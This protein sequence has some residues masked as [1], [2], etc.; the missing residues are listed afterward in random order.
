MR[1]DSCASCVRN[2]H[3]ALAATAAAMLL[4]GVL[5]A[6]AQVGWQPPPVLVSGISGSLGAIFEPQIATDPAGNAVAVWMESDPAGGLAVY[7]ARY[8]AATHTWLAPERRS[9]LGVT[10]AAQ[11]R[12]AVD[13]AGQAV[14]MWEQFM[15]GSNSASVMSTRYSPSAGTWTTPEVRSNGDAQGV[16]VAMNAAGDA[17]AVWSVYAG[18][19]G[20]VPS[21]VYSSRY[22]ASTSTLT[23]QERIDIDLGTGLP[24]LDVAIDGAGNAT[25]VWAYQTIQARRFAAATSTWE[26]RADLSAPV[27]GTTLPFPNVAMNSAGDA[28]AS[29]MRNGVVEVARRPALSVT[30]TAAEAV[31]A[32]AD[33]GARPAIDSAGNSIVAWYHNTATT[34]TLQA[35]RFAVAT[36]AWTGLA[37]IVPSGVPRAV[38]QGYAPPALAVDARDNVHVVG[39]RSLDGQSMR[40]VTAFY[41]AASGT[42]SSV[43][44][45]STAGHVARNPDVATDAAGNALAVWFQAAGSVSANLGLRWSAA[46]AAPIVGAAVPSPGMLSVAVSPAPSL[47]PA[48]APTSIHYS[49]DGGATWTARVPAGVVSPL[50]ISG[51]TDGVTYDVQLRAVNAA[52]AGPASAALPVRSG[53]G[54]DTVTTGLRVATRAGNAVTFTWLAPSAG[55]VPTGYLIEGSISGQSQVLASVPTGG[56]A[57]QVT[58]VVPDGTFD[59]RV[60]AV[61]G[62]LRLATSLPL[63]VAVNTLAFPSSPVNLLASAAGDTLALSWTN[64]WSGATL[65]GLQLLVGGSAGATITLPVTES[66]TFSGVPAGTYTFAV[67]AL[68]GGAPGGATSTVQLTFPGTCAGP[69]NPPTAFSLST[70]GGRVYLNWLP[71][72]SGAAVTHYVVQATGAFTGSFPLATRTFSAP[73]PPGSY[74][75]SVASVGPCGTSAATAPQT[76]VVP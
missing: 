35:N 57:T 73:V 71:P 48:L 25:V 42:W 31:S 41:A 51:L 27:T 18:F 54:L 33:D 29:W 22:T 50:E 64:T 74:S 69:P 52:G 9:P 56:A 34:R 30:W 49:L 45:L 3:A 13:A 66:F 38:L 20:N 14:A 59:V 17:V 24:S 63:Q 60:V 37:D 46:P 10:S 16:Q 53:S 44:D 76:V 32:G 70:Q 26:A 28:V 5:T 72:S 58:L 75:V 36:S 68:N 11:P 23:P 12:V 1:L 21:G 4:A 43:A 65:T 39:V 7:S 8:V 6:S 40:V 55:V 2:R 15:P 67:T 19:G 61:H 62:A 47:D